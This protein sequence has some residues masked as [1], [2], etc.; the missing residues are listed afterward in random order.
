MHASNGPRAVVAKS[1]HT[2]I[3]LSASPPLHLSV[4]PPVGLSPVACR[5]SCLSACL[6]VAT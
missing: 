6:P 2:P 1:Q 3:R 5:L 4:C